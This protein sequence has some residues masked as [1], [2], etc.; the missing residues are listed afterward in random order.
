MAQV[1]SQ[2]PKSPNHNNISDSET[3]LDGSNPYNSQNTPHNLQNGLHSPHNTSDSDDVDDM[4]FFKKNRGSLM[5]VAILAAGST[6]QAGLN[7]PGSV[8]QDNDTTPHGHKAGNPILHD[9]FFKRYQAFFY[10]NAVSF[11][12]SLVIIIFLMNRK[13]Y[14][15][16]RKIKVLE[17]TMVLDLFSFMAAY[18]VGSC[19]LVSSSIYVFLIMG[20]VFIYVISFARHYS[21][22]HNFAT[23]MPCGCTGHVTRSANVA[24]ARPTEMVRA[25]EDIV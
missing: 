18:A 23:K 22:L 7:P 19:R 8:W 15:N 12:S 17:I 16:K 4:T 21:V 10:C 6:Y 11:L 3:N 25:G 2:I 1:N 13:F 20:A 5:I 14:C 9:M 24:Q